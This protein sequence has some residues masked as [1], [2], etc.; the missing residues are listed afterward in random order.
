VIVPDDKDWT[1]VLDRPCPV[2]DFDASTCS[3]NAVPLLVR[4]NAHD[5]RQLLERGTIRAGRAND[6]TWSSLEYAC[7]VRDVFRRYDERIALMQRE[8]DP[9]FPNWD[10]MRQRL[11]I[12]TTH[13]SRFTSSKRCTPRQRESLHD[14]SRFRV[15]SGNVLADEATVLRSRSARSRAT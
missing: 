2:C 6:A 4:E 15:T 10:Q 14:S 3:E 1:W 7:H 12:D 9:L 11:M 13:K 5:W 8:D